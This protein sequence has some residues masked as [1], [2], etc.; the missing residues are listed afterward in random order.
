ML[1]QPRA[2]LEESASKEGMLRQPPPLSHS[3]SFTI[4]KEHR[5]PALPIAVFFRYL[6][7]VVKAVHYSPTV[8][9]QSALSFTP[10]PNNLNINT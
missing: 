10:T 4:A 3:T 6:Q 9:H 7:P 8:N 5:V 1:R 2:L